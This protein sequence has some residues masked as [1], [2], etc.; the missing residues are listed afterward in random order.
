VLLVALRNVLR[1][2]R[3]SFIALVAIAAGVAALVFAGGFI[4]W[5]LRELREQ[6]IRSQL[7]HIQ[8]HTQTSTSLRSQALLVP[9]VTATA[10]I[11][12]VP[13][14]VSVSRRM[15]VSGLISHGDATLAFVGTGIEPSTDPS[16]S[17]EDVISGRPLDAAKPDGILV[18]EGLAA[19]LELHPGDRSVLI[20]S[21]PNGGVTGRDVIVSGIFR[22]VSKAYDDA[23]LRIPLALAQQLRKTEGSDLWVIELDET[24]A[25]DATLAA[26]RGDPTLRNFRFIPWTELADFYNKAVALY[27]R[28]FT[29]MKVLIAVI[30]V[31]SIMNTM[32]MSVSERTWEIGTMMALGTPRHGIVQ[33]FVWEGVVLGV[34]GGLAG[35]A[36]GCIIN[37][38]VSKTGIPM[39]PPPGMS[40]GFLAQASLNVGITVSAFL[41]AVVATITASFSPAFAAS[42]LVIVDALRASR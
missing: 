1:Q 24:E 28:Q 8:V 3:R 16:A 17:A 31:L 5:I 22:S 36:L 7:G 9:S 12:R 23:A 38:V 2:Q 14:V 37:G 4:D 10:R 41:L 35:V 27:A 32:M 39:P 29:V 18:G 6:T 26:L 40:H 42:R 34:I 20:V 30:I 11:Q 21:L 19:A 15:D 25:T 13:H 33:I